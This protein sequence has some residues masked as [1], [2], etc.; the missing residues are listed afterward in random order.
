[1][2]HAAG[3]LFRVQKS[4]SGGK[5]SVNYH[6]EIA[7]TTSSLSASA[8][9]WREDLWAFDSIEDEY[10][11]ND[12]IDLEELRRALPDAASLAS[13]PKKQNKVHQSEAI[14]EAAPVR[15]TTQEVDNQT[16]GLMQLK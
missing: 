5:S 11:G 15:K 1:M 13:Y 3:G 8:S 16:P 6:A 7:P 4:F 9:D 12:D 2:T 10:A 14:V